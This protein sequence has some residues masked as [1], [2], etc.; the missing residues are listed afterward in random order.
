MVWWLARR[1]QARRREEANDAIDDMRRERSSRS[2]SRT[3]TFL[4]GVR[5]RMGVLKREEAP[6]ALC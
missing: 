6:T 5:R 2:T 4:L 1:P 3:R